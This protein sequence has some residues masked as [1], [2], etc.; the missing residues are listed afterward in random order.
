MCG[1]PYLSSQI[2]HTFLDNNDPWVLECGDP[3]PDLG[4]GAE[5]AGAVLQKKCLVTSGLQLDC[6]LPATMRRRGWSRALREGL[7]APEKS[8]AGAREPHY[9]TSN[10]GT[11]L[12]QSTSF[13]QEVTLFSITIIS[14]DE[15]LKGWCLKAWSEYFH[16]GLDEVLHGDSGW[17]LVSAYFEFFGQVKI[18]LA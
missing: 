9:R 11:F 5:T 3:G 15:L 1:N 18:N 14:L 16:L 17:W 7:C 12:H 4:L 8:R 2:G 6:L 10:L 13:S